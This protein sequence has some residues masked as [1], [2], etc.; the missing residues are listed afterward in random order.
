[1]FHIKS[2]LV[3]FEIFLISFCFC[4]I[5]LEKKD[6]LLNGFVRYYNSLPNQSYNCEVGYLQNAQQIDE[7]CYKIEI[8]IKAVNS[9][10]TK[11]FK[12]TTT[13]QELPENAINV[14]N[15]EYQCTEQGDYNGG[16]YEEVVTVTTTEQPFE[17]RPVELDNEVETN[18]AVTSGEQFIAIP[19]VHPNAPCIGCSTH[20]NPQ[21]A[22]VSE[23]AALGAKQL[24]RHVPNIKHTVSGVLDVERQVQVVNG[25]RYILT[26]LIDFEIESCKEDVTNNDF[27]KKTETCKVTILE[28]PWV[29]YADGS[30]Y[31]AILANNCTDYWLFGDDGEVILDDNNTNK[32]NSD[33]DINSKHENSGDDVIKPIHNIEV[34]SQQNQEK[35][36]NEQDVKNIEQQIIPLNKFNENFDLIGKTDSKASINNE[37]GKEHN[38]EVESSPMSSNNIVH[39]ENKDGI[40]SDDKKKTIDDLIRFFDSAGFNNEPAHEEH[41]SRSRRSYD[42]DV[43]AM[44]LAERFTNIKQSINNAKH[45]FSV[46]QAMVDHLNEI[47][48]DIKTKKLLSVLKAEEEFDGDNHYFYIQ[49]RVSTPCDRFECESKAIEVKICNGVIDTSKQIFKVLSAFCSFESD[50]S[51]GNKINNVPLDDPVLQHLAKSAVTEIERSSK[52]NMALKLNKILSA[53]KQKVGGTLTKLSIVLGF[54]NCSKTVPIVFRNDCILEDEMGLKL[55]EVLIHEKL[56]MKDQ[57]ITYT[58]IDRPVH[59]SFSNKLT[60]KT[61]LDDSKIRSMVQTALEYLEMQS[62]KKNKQKIVSVNSVRTQLSAG[63]L[64]EIEFTVGYTSCVDNQIT[65]MND[66]STCVLLEDEP[67]RNCKA[68]IWDRSWIEDGTQIEVSCKDPEIRFDGDEVSTHR[69]KRSLDFVGGPVPKDAKD[70]QYKDLADESLIKFMLGSG[71]KQHYYVVNVE[72]VT[73]Q[74]VA[75]TLTKIT[76]TITPTTCQIDN[77]GTVS[78]PNC[79]IINSTDTATCHSTI[80]YQPWTAHGKTVTVTCDT[81]K[82]KRRLKHEAILGGFSDQDPNNPR[83]TALA[84]CSLQK[85]LE[86]SGITLPNKY[87]KVN[88][89]AVQIVSGTITLVDFTVFPADGDVFDCRSKIW[90]QP[91]LN[92]KEIE[93][94]CD[95]ANRSKRQL[96]GGK[97]EQNANDPKYKALAEESLVK[98]LQT[99]GWIAPHIVV[100]VTK[101]TSQVVSGT[102]IFVDFTASPSSGSV[103][104]TFTCRSKIWE[105][106]WLNKKEIEVD[107]DLANRSK[108]QLPGGKSEQNANDPKYKALAEESLVKY[109]Q[110]T[111]VT[112]PH[113]V[114]KVT[115]VTSQVVSG[116]NIFVDFTASP[117]SGSVEDTFTCRSKIWEQPWL[118]KKEIEVDC[119]LANRSKRQLP[120]GQRERNANDPK[121]KALAEES[122]VKYLQTTGVS[123][124]YIVVEVN[125]VTTQVVS[126]T[127]T[128]VDFTASPSS[129]SIGDTFTCRSKIWEQPWLKKKEIEVV[130]DPA[131]RSKRQ[132]P[133]GHHFVFKNKKEEIPPELFVHEHT[134]VK[135]SEFSQ[136]DKISR[137]KRETLYDD[138]PDFFRRRTIVNIPERNKTAGNVQEQDPSKIEYKL[139]AQKSLVKYLKSKQMDK[140]HKVIEVKR[141]RTQVVSGILYK[142]DFKAAPTTCSANIDLS[143]LESCSLENGIVLFCHAD[144][145][146]KLWLHQEDIKVTCN[147]KRNEANI[148]T[149]PLNRIGQKL[150]QNR[151][152]KR[153]A[154]PDEDDIEEDNKHYYADLAV[155]HLNHISDSHNLYKLVTI[156]TVKKRVVM[157]STLIMMYIEVAQ[158]Y[159]LRHADENILPECEE[160]DGMDHKN[161]F[162]R[163][164]PSS[165]DEL[166]IIHTD[167]ICDDDSKFEDIT[168]ISLAKLLQASISRIESST[169]VKNKVVH[170]GDPQWIPTLD[171]D[172]PV[173]LNFIIAT[174]NCSKDVDFIKKRSECFYDITVPSKACNSYIWLAPFTNKVDYVQVSCQSTN[175][176][177]KRALGQNA[178]EDTILINHLVQLSLDKLEMTSQHRYKQRLLR[179]NRYSTKITSG[180]VTTIDFDVGYTSCLKYEWIDNVTSCEFLQHLPRRHC[181]SQI[182]ERLW[183][184][185]GRNIDVNCED[186]E[187]P[188][189]SHI[190]FESAEMGMQLAKEA[191]KHIEAKYPNPRKQQVVRIFTLEKQVVAGLHYRM[192]IEVGSTNCFALSAETNCKLDK[193]AGL[194]KFCRV[195]VWL[196]PW[197]D[198]P[199]NFRVQCDYQDTAVGEV[200]HHVQAEYLFFNFLT[201]YKPDYINDHKEMGRRFDIFKNNIRKIHDLNIHERGTATYGLTRFADL[202][203]EEFSTKYMGLKPSLKEDNRMP[204]RPATIPNV[205]V[206]ES[207][208]WREFDAVTAVK[209]QGSCGSCWAFSVTGNIEGQ[210]KMQSGELLSLSEQEL[211]DCDKMDQGCDGG[212]MDNAYRAIEQLGGLELEN[213]YP[214]EAGDDKCVYN[215]TLSKVQISGAVNISSNETDMAKWLV[216]NGPIS[217]GINANAMQFYMGGISHPWRTL[218]NP[219]NLDHGV[220]LVGYGIKDYPLF[221]KRLPYWIVK[222]SWGPSWGEQGYYRVFRG[223]GTCG[224]NQMASSAVI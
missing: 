72:N 98:Y 60:K 137:K 62:N 169:Q 40:I 180:K 199:P 103:E 164:T 159:C 70:P 224:V 99:T 118:N 6:K 120:G 200:Y 204:T 74:V 114:V 58:C 175:P 207:F 110:T 29:R 92:K 19:K 197:T 205:D 102:N 28:K 41:K 80:F 5:S 183:I 22:G 27:C 162:A 51:A 76:F 57:R 84:E 133:D 105:Q 50:F 222:N 8:I 86:T 108:R 206:P 127:I 157:D 196:R 78:S 195:N 3:L 126:G 68:L 71:E 39:L 44:L 124:P 154:Y 112:T 171:P 220:L 23:L 100:K 219:K 138:K 43:A 132:I 134:Y 115:K 17:R 24:D 93:V 75:G 213:D 131:N 90:E 155:Q 106:P 141:V 30:K 186:D 107:C 4:E 198:H 45:V 217:I 189:E 109:L 163:L 135:S 1:M 223:D 209:D 172:V 125:K 119:D 67:M 215:K 187:T 49:A 87:I 14:M 82:I 12:C 9:G 221:N 208:D 32:G 188:L 35:V 117:S 15:N 190:E 47:D 95:L 158:T 140:A 79:K 69:T 185:N 182:W 144:I 16:A 152:W 21:A 148:T 176:R 61:D 66:S 191:L 73:V 88:K 111:G 181:V 128:R 36:L 210:W 218:C 77:S 166:I 161:C 94:D 53:N 168:G 85:Y 31:K 13:L 7:N 145:W 54:L 52:G 178:T 10:A 170:I 167:V 177:V 139:L 101:V 104:D 212:L 91:W 123:T 165:D 160:L 174:T 184:N 193:D 129:G 83:Y 59:I 156:H 26:L 11:Y 81:E 34:Q 122:L 25:I 113:I 37:I 20:I 89:V 63:F 214:Y 38:Q 48:S 33:G 151:R 97:S 2:V 211:V 192:K 143:I 18:T 64:I 147:V 216:K 46:A 121:Y 116:T 179:V 203:Y 130:C 136:Y 202:T 201:T 146:S 42:N 149:T 96:P 55:C 65:D 173:K 153:Q 56:R 194:N 142:I 150:Q